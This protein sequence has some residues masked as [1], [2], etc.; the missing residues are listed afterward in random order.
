MSTTAFQTQY[1][2]EFIKGF[3]QRQSLLRDA[4]TTEAVIKG[5]TAVFLVADSGGASAVTRGADGRI[6]GRAD[7]KTANSCTLAEW[8]DVPELTGFNIFAGQGDQR[9]LLQQTSMGVI[10]R[11]IDS[12]IITALSGATITTGAA[13]IASLGLVTKAKATLSAAKVPADG[14]IFCAMSAGFLNFLSQVKEF[15]NADYVS[16][17]PLD[18]DNASFSDSPGYYRWLNINWIECPELST[19]A[20]TEYAY[21]FHRSAIGHAIDKNGIQTY[22][23][24]DGRQDF[25]YARCTAYMGSKLLQ[26]SGVVKILHDSSAAYGS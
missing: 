17:K 12:D 14:Q 18:G 4:T 2:Q 9:A 20:S 11:K 22:V 16:K 1:R 21:M 3:E 10:N 25:S 13:Q 26:N 8:H 15:A 6:P 23:D 19:K 7:N 24:Y 5:N